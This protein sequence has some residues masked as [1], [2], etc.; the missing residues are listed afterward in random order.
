MR[1][2][3]K[4][5][6]YRFNGWK[7]WLPKAFKGNQIFIGHKFGPKSFIFLFPNVLSFLGSL[8]SFPFL[9]FSFV[10]PCHF[11]LKTEKENVL[12]A[13]DVKSIGIR[14][15]PIF[16]AKKKLR[17]FSYSFLEFQQISIFSFYSTIPF[18][19]TILITKGQ[20]LF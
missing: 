7:R 10:S 5:Q 17:K 2:Y 13:K 19:S 16:R 6:I 1:K 15:G 4:I 8:A 9:L 14:L 20:C 12:H 11:F 3:G 18:L